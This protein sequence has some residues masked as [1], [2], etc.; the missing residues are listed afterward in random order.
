MLFPGIINCKYGGGGTG[1][2]K[3]IVKGY[4]D[5]VDLLLSYQTID[6]NSCVYGARNDE[7]LITPLMLA[8]L[9]GREDIAQKLILAGANINTKAPGANN[10]SAIAFAMVGGRESFID[11]FMEYEETDWNSLDNNGTSA[12]MEAVKRNQVETLKKLTRIPSINWNFRNNV[13][14]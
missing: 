12:A 3:A 13:E 9:A 2:T 8:C 5:I 11:L 10:I 4:T 6:V 1:L 14:Q 7:R